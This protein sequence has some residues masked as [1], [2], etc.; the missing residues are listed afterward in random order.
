MNITF[1]LTMAFA[2]STG[3][4]PVVIDNIQSRQ[5]CIDMATSLINA[6]RFTKGYTVNCDVRV[7]KEMEEALEKFSPI[8][9]CEDPAVQVCLPSEPYPNKKFLQ[10]APIDLVGG[11]EG[12]R[13][14]PTMPGVVLMPRSGNS[15]DTAAAPAQQV[16]P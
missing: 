14:A 5:E 7:T 15:A 11:N 8:L 2:A 16:E 13:T 1:K 12:L 4:P 6:T 10:S 3:M 9:L